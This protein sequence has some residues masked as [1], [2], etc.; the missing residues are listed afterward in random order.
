MAL[1][2]V[3]ADNWNI[4]GPYKIYRPISGGSMNPV[5]TLGPAIASGCYKGLW[6][7]ML[8][9]VVGTLLGSLSYRLIRV[10]DNAVH[11]ISPSFS[12]KLHPNMTNDNKVDP[13]NVV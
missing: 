2:Q 11:A 10:D 7:Y 9:P 4:T 1:I 13:S 3:G 5:R 6:V 12:F 8:G